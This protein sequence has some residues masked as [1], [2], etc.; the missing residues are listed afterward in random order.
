MVAACRWLSPLQLFVGSEPFHQPET[1][2]WRHGVKT[3]LRIVSCQIHH[4][5]DFAEIFRKN[6]P[7][8][9]FPATPLLNEQEFIVVFGCKKDH[10]ADKILGLALPPCGDALQEIR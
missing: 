2:R 8:E 9:I 6:V 3:D 4:D 1:F 7:S 10:A 5:Q